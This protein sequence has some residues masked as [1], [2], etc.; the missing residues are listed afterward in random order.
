MVVKLILLRFLCVCRGMVQYAFHGPPTVDPPIV[1]DPARPDVQV[2]PLI[3]W[4]WEKS[5]ILEQL[6]PKP[7]TL[8]GAIPDDPPRE[9]HFNLTP[10]PYFTAFKPSQLMKLNIP[11]IS[12]SSFI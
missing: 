5:A 9:D 6:K 11:A 8:I 2:V 1:R 7:Q 3:P 4:T 12:Q 10:T